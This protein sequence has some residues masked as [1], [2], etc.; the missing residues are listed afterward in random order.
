MMAHAAPRNRRRR[1]SKWGW[2]ILTL[3]VYTVAA[4]QALIMV[5]GFVYV[6]WTIWTALGV[7]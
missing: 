1:L 5:L 2:I 4:I 7:N 3:A 6:V